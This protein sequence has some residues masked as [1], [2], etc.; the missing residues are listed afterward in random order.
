[1]RIAFE[2]LH[3]SHTSPFPRALRMYALTY[4]HCAI[5]KA[6]E[7]VCS[8]LNRFRTDLAQ[9]VLPVSSFSTYSSVIISPFIVY[10]STAAFHHRMG[11]CMQTFLSV[12][13][14]NVGGIENCLIFTSKTL[15]KLLFVSSPKWQNSSVKTNV[16]DSSTSPFLLPSA[17]FF[18]SDHALKIL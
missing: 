2:T 13:V 10:P 16:G 11:K 12:S 8:Y 14:S 9:F 5:L 1:M 4:C 6:S 15:N 18:V 3:R 17:S 7:R